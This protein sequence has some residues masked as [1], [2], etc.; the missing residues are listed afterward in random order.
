MKTKRLMQTQYVRSVRTAAW[1]SVVS[2]ADDGGGDGKNAEDASAS[3]GCI[4]AARGPDVAVPF[5]PP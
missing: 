3:T 4:C 2:R 5:D 1:T